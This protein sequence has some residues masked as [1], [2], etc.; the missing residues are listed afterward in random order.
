MT[1]RCTINHHIIHH[2]HLPLAHLP[3]VGERWRRSIT[4]TTTTHSTNS[5]SSSNPN[6]KRCCCCCGCYCCCWWY[7]LE[8]ELEEEEKDVNATTNH[9]ATSHQPMIMFSTAL[10]KVSSAQRSWSGWIITAVN[11][12]TTTSCQPIIDG[13]VLGEVC[14][15][16][17]WAKLRLYIITTLQST[18]HRSHPIVVK[19]VVGCARANC[20]DIAD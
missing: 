20:H 3:P 5:L 17:L 7:R 19:C 11:Q 13:A 14:L 1:V 4:T 16:A 15:R 18:Y 12:S 9:N 6:S 10:Y 2:H 8:Y